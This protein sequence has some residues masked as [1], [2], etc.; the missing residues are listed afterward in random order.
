MAFEGDA[1]EAFA[2]VAPYRDGAVYVSYYS[3]SSEWERHPNGDE[4]VM[5]LEGTTTVILLG[6]AGE[7]RFSLVEQELIVIPKGVWHRF[8]GSDRLKVMTITPQP[9]EHSLDTPTT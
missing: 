3:G 5:V 2:E 4:V 7:E 6:N 9:T 8:E 1:S